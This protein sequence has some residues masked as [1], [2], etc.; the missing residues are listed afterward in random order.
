M[1]E[2]SSLI[3]SKKPRTGTNGGELIRWRCLRKWKTSKFRFYRHG[4]PCQIYEFDGE[5]EQNKSTINVFMVQHQQMGSTGESL[6]PPDTDKRRYLHQEK[7][8]KKPSTTRL[9]RI[10]GTK[11]GR[12]ITILTT[13]AE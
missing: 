8:L 11:T 4:M 6:R 2:R 3:F 9:K 5:D 1:K 13:L 7:L 12:T 10:K